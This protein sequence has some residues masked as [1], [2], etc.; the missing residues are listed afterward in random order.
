MEHLH[1]KVQL[2]GS[3]VVYVRS[4]FVSACLVQIPEG[5]IPS[6]MEFVCPWSNTSV[7][8]MSFDEVRSGPL[9]HCELCL[10]LLFGTRM[11][12]LHMAYGLSD[13]HEATNPDRP[14][15]P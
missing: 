11:A 12:E 8:F 15:K 4:I 3:G 6:T 5:G 9:R 10:S 13:L 14:E 1:Q 2:L 7:T